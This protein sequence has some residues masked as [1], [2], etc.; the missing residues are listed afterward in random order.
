MILRVKN[1]LASIGAWKKQSEGLSEISRGSSEATPPE[2][3]QNKSSIPE[4]CQSDVFFLMRNFWHPF[5]VLGFCDRLPG[6]S[7]APQPPA[8]F[9]QS[10]GLR[11]G[12]RAAEAQAEGKKKITPWWRTLKTSGELNPKYPGGVAAQSKLLKAEGHEI[13]PGKGKKAPRLKCDESSVY[14]FGGT[15]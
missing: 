2:P 5:R 14:C 7:A 12:M 3:D 1:N 13:I 10:F 11:H 9:W 4:G 8:N 15:K 6:V